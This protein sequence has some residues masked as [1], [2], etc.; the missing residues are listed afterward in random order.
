MIRYRGALYK[1]I[2]L[3]NGYTIKQSNRGEVTAVS[4]VEELHDAILR[5]VYFNDNFKNEEKNVFN[6]TPKGWVM[7]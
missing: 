4:N 5:A 3:V 7:L 2:Y 6:L 1:N